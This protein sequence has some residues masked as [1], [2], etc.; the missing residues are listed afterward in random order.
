[1]TTEE[2]TRSACAPS[3]QAA[4][5]PTPVPPL[6]PIEGI[7]DT[8]RQLDSNLSD[9][10]CL[11]SR[12]LLDSERRGRDVLKG[13]LDTPTKRFRVRVCKVRT[14]NSF[15]TISEQSAG[16]LTCTHEL[17]LALRVVNSARTGTGALRVETVGEEGLVPDWNRS[18]RHEVKR[19]DFLLEV[20]GVRNDPE[21]ISTTLALDSILDILIV[22]PPPQFQM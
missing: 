11:T 18:H 10:E 3:V 4:P 17:G 16:D 1:M 21:R 9:T 13:K 7:S 8:P 6:P 2:K 15:Q 19:G 14:T 5:L 22:R 12:G 20:N